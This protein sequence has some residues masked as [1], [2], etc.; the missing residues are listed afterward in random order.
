MMSTQWP[1]V[2][3]AC[4]LVLFVLMMVGCKGVTPCSG[5]DYQCQK[6]ALRADIARQCQQHW[7]TELSAEISAGL[8]YTRDIAQQWRADARRLIP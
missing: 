2:F 3:V 7:Y 4:C 6:R 8:H 1:R 5:Y